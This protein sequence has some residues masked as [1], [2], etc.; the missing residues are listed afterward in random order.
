[1]NLQNIKN[2][3]KEILEEDYVDVQKGTWNDN[4]HFIHVR[5]NY[6]TLYQAMEIARICGDADP[7]FCA[8]INDRLKILV[9]LKTKI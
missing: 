3:L 1:M 9:N 4:V 5:A 7:V 8:D 2:K 6:C